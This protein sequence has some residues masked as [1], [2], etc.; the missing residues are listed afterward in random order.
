VPFDADLQRLQRDSEVLRA[1]AHPL[2]LAMLA[3]L[4]REGRL[5]VSA[6]HEALAIEQ[7]VA[8]HH[9][10]ILKRVDVV[11]VDRQGKHSFYFVPDEAIGGILDAL[12]RLGEA[13]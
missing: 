8:S 11:D 13:G 2:R 12:A 7:A 10:R 6:I 9:L 1:M 4:R 3:L 5:S